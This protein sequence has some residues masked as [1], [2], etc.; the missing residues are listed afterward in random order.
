MSR[1]R[2]GAVAAVAAGMSL[3]GA[4]PVHATAVEAAPCQFLMPITPE[5][6]TYCVCVRVG[7]VVILVLPDS[8]GCQ[9]P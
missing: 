7:Q 2:K 8:W 4:A 3:V 9:A 6:V 1:I 5:D